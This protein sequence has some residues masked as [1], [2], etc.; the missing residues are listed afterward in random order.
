MSKMQF[1][2]QPAANIQRKSVPPAEAKRC[3]KQQDALKESPC[4]GKTKKTSSAIVSGT[5]RL[6]YSVYFALASLP[7]IPACSRI[8]NGKTH[9]GDISI[10]TIAG[11]AV[12]SGLVLISAI[13]IQKVV[14][15]IK[16]KPPKK[17]KHVIEKKES[18]TNW[19]IEA[20]P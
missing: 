20:D 19:S 10:L 8:E 17:E 11:M 14:D 9:T 4:G 13:G 3:L 1:F 6:Y 15:R 2:R 12:V 7:F 18:P 16:N 5:K